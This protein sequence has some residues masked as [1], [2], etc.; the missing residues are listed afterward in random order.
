LNGQAMTRKDLKLLCLSIL[1]AVAVEH[2]AGH[3]AVYAARY[4]LRGESGERIGLM[5]EKGETS[6]AN[7]WVARRFAEGLIDTGIDVRD[8][9]AVA[10]YQASE[11]GAKRYGRHAALKTMR[12]L[13]NV[14][15]VRFTIDSVS[16]LKLIINH[17]ARL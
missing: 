12:D 13:A 5:F 16:Q 4:V 8:Y 3:Q 17:L 1:D 2:P 10:L 6:A 7:L 11:G 9:P 14:D 15:L